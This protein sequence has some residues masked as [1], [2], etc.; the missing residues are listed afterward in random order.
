MALLVRQ[1]NDGGAG[2]FL[3]VK[4]CDWQWG[5]GLFLVLKGMAGDCGTVGA[6]GRDSVALGVETWVGECRLWH[7]Q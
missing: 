3:A 1:G 6:E 7:K 5:P 4:G 2:L